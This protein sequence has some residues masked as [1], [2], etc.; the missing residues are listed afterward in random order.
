M[1]FSGKGKTAEE[2][3]EDRMEMKGLSQME[4]NPSRFQGKLVDG[5]QCWLCVRLTGTDDPVGMPK[6]SQHSVLSLLCFL[7]FLSSQI[8]HTAS[9]DRDCGHSRPQLD[10]VIRCKACFYLCQ[11]CQVSLKI[12]FP[13]FLCL[14]I[15]S[16]PED[17]ITVLLKH[18]QG[19]PAC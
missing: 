8:T 19:L 5:G 16:N 2:K 9:Q 17:V 6:A 1:D 13:F 12:N 7:L 18:Q 11:Q 14:L 4:K 10:M 15:S 3:G